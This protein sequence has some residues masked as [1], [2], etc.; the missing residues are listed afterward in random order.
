MSG[1]L[2]KPLAITAMGAISAV[3]ANAPQTCTSIRAGLAGFTEHPYF[4]SLSRDPEWEPGEPLIAASCSQLNPFAEGSDRLLGLAVPPIIELGSQARLRRTDLAESAFLLALPVLDDAVQ[5]W[6]LEKAFVE[7]LLCMT[8]LSQFKVIRQSHSG[9]TGMFELLNEAHTLLA[10]GQAR[11]CFLLGVDS[12]L[13][14]DRMEL[15]DQL[16]RLRS[17]RNADG[18]LPGE[19]AS[20]V[21][22]EL[23]ATA[24]ARSAH[25]RA[26]VAALG[27]GDESNAFT[28][29]NASTGAGL[30]KALSEVIPAE[31]G[32]RWVCCDLNGESYRAF[33]WG[34][35][36]V[37]L[38]EALAGMA[39][40][41]HT[42]ESVGDVG[43]ATGGIL[44]NHV[45][46]ALGRPHPPATEGILWTS[47][48][49]GKRA[50][51]RM[52]TAPPG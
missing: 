39:T 19:A 30:C 48:D 6:Q 18:F 9:H 40:L 15:W 27:F 41:H 31:K 10:G 20:A 34:L 43:A 22:V 13:S 17:E 49:D 44:M 5:N 1:T 11:Y 50:A 46:Y 28:S 29:E 37:R 2:E 14:P 47:A 36:R 33:E 16:W 25:I 38:H 35:A 4:E 42:A 8:G 21:L 12:Y 45:A 7:R 26:T 23:Q 52:T 3:G 32:A 24:Q 51:M